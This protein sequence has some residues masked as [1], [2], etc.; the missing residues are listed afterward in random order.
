[1]TAKA[2][3]Q[4]SFA[5][6]F[7][8]TPDGVELELTHPRSKIRRLVVDSSWKS[9]HPSPGLIARPHRL[10]YYPAPPTLHPWDNVSLTP[11][12]MPF[13]ALTNEDDYIATHEHIQ[14]RDIAVGFGRF[15]PACLFGE[16]MLNAGLPESETNE[17]VLEGERGYRG[18]APG[19]AEITIWLPGGLGYLDVLPV[20]ESG[21]VDSRRCH[22]EETRDVSRSRQVHLAHD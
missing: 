12:D 22:P 20:G 6:A 15:E 19:S 10:G 1:M 5:C 17:I 13:L 11:W 16:L 4:Q 2:N 18:V 14:S 7:H 9:A 21:S 8:E 3:G